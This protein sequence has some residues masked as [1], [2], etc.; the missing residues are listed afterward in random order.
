MINLAEG[1][2]LSEALLVEIDSSLS[3]TKDHL[4]THELVH[5]AS[6][7][8]SLRNVHGVQILMNLVVTSTHTEE[9]TRYLRCLLEFVKLS[10]FFVKEFQEA[11]DIMS[12]KNVFRLFVLSV[13]VLN[14]NAIADSDPIAVAHDSQC[15]LSFQ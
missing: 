5:G 12:I 6:D 3:D 15:H 1:V 13:L 14:L 8:D 11:R 10:V 9:V 4:S 7:K 2:P